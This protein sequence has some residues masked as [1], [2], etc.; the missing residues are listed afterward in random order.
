MYRHTHTHTR[1]LMCWPAS[2][3]RYWTTMRLV[4]S[5][6]KIKN[7]SLPRHFWSTWTH[8]GYCAGYCV[9]LQ[10]HE[11]IQ[12]MKTLD[13]HIV[14]GPTRRRIIRRRKTFPSWVMQ[15]SFSKFPLFTS[16]YDMHRVD[17]CLTSVEWD[18]IVQ[19]FLLSRHHLSFLR[20]NKRRQRWRKRNSSCIH[21]TFTASPIQK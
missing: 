7:S 1:D 8:I 4:S 11:P 15:P 20:K 9:H 21:S 19:L 17:G 16:S 10:G 14:N 13:I 18:F 2:W 12:R 3:A 5:G 6:R